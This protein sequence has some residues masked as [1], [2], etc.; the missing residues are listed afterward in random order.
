MRETKGRVDGSSLRFDDIC[1]SDFFLAQIVTSSPP[2]P[3]LKKL[4]VAGQLT[5]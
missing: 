1:W 3:P 5:S 4:R 2:L